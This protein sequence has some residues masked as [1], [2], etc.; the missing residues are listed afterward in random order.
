VTT[1]RN[2]PAGAKILLAW[3][4]IVIIAGLFGNFW[5]AVKALEARDIF[6]GLFFSGLGIGCG[7]LCYRTYLYW[8]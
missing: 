3:W 2:T 5:M 7:V 4:L 1:K 8:D 6:A